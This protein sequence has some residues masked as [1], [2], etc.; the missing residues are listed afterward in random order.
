MHLMTKRLTTKIRASKMVRPHKFGLLRG[1]TPHLPPGLNPMISVVATRRLTLVA[2]VCLT[3]VLF[4]PSLQYAQTLGEPQQEQLLNGLKILMW[5]RPNDPNVLLKL[6]IHSGAA[7]DLAGKPGEMALLGD[8]LFPDPAT[9]DYFTDEMQGKLTVVTDYDGITITMQGR[10]SEFAQITE[11]LRNGVVNTQLSAEIVNSVRDGR[12]K[13]LKDTSI[14]APMV[15]DRAIAARL[16]GDHPYGRPSN[17]SPESLARIERADLM[18]ARDRFLNPNNATLAIVGNVQPNR[19]LRVLRQLL[20]SWRKSE[21]IVP[22]TF[23]QPAPPEGRTLIINGPGDDSVEVRIAARGTSRSDKDS[24]AASLVA[25]VMRDRWQKLMPELD[26]SPVFVRHEARVLPGMFV[27]G[28]TVKTA[29]AQKALTTAKE[30]VKSVVD[31]GITA[32]ELDQAKAEAISAHNKALSNAEETA[33]AWLN[34]ATYKLTT[35]NEELALL[36]RLSSNDV[37]RVAASIFGTSTIASVVVGNAEQLRAQLERNIPIEVLGEIK[38]EPKSPTESATPK[39][40]T[41][42]KPD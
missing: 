40:A 29:S 38:P 37:Q 15:A 23:R 4:R 10:P 32:T 42:G 12:I 33:E 17:G 1:I 3:I 21:Q 35:P 34:L 30:V 36:Q 24:L 13:I 11:I 8:I 28:A 7:F 26:R 27:L 41:P 18:L 16:F 2:I 5:P 25:S 39:L 19:A 9:R 31:G 14:S 20:G 22:A 6:R